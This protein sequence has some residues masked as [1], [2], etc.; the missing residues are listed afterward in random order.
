MVLNGTANN[1]YPIEQALR[2]ISAYA[3]FATVF[4]V[5]DL[6]KNRVTKAELTVENFPEGGK[7]GPT[8]TMTLDNLFVTPKPTLVVGSGYH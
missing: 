3:K 5:Y 1:V 4:A 8:S 7:V 2:K 6:S